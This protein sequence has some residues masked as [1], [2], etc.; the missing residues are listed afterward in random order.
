MGTLLR[1]SKITWSSL[2][3]LKNVAPCF[4]QIS[5]SSCDSLL[6]GEREKQETSPIANPN[7]SMMEQGGEREKNHTSNLGMGESV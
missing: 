6:I 2:L 7:L 3:W 4:A 5:L 1:V